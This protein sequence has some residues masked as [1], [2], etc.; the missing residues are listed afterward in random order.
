M[1]AAKLR[2]QQLVLELEGNSILGKFQSFQRKLSHLIITNHL[3]AITWTMAGSS[4]NQQ[5]AVDDVNAAFGV[6]G[7]TP[8]H[9][10]TLNFKV[11]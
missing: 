7:A 2:P 5:Q 8:K 3:I 11:E 9:Q 1:A 6:P 10:K 4:R